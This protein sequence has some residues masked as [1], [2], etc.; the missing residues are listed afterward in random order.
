MSIRNKEY[1]ELLKH[2]FNEEKF[3]EFVIDLLNLYDSDLNRNVIENTITTKQFKDNILH[4]KHIANYNDGLNNIGVFIIKLNN[5]TTTQSRNMQRNFVATLLSKYNLDAC[6]VSFYSDRETS[7]RLSFVKRELS[8]TDKGIKENLTSAKRYSYLVGEHESVHTAQEF[9]FKLL[10][11]DNR[12]IT[13]EDIEKQFD[14]EKVT[15]KFF[16]EYKDKYL[17]LKEFFDKNEDFQTE[18]KNCDFDSVEFA[19]KLMG[20]IVFLYFLQKKGWLGVQLIP[21]ELSVDEYN[22]L[23]SNNDSVSQNLIRQYFVLNDDKYIVEKTKLRI[24]EIPEDIINLTNVFANTKYN[25]PWGTGRKDFIRNIFNQ[26]KIEHKNFFD[27]YLEYFFYKGLNEKRENQYFPLFN[28]KI[29]FLN[30]GLFEPLN[31]YRWSSAHFEIPNSIFSNDDKNG[32]L[33]FLDLY[34]FTIDEEEPLEKEI[35]VDPEMLGKIFENLLEIDDRKS[36]GAFYTPREIVYYMCQES[37]ANYLVNKLKINYNEIIEFIKFGDSIS[38]LDWETHLNNENSFIIGESVFEN[39]L[40]I[41]KALID[42]KVADPSV[43]SGAFPLGILNEIVKIRNNISTY[44]LILN[45]NGKIDIDDSFINEFGK[46]DLYEMKLQTIENSIYAV[47][48]ETSAIDI[49]KLRLWLSLIVDYPN[50]EEPKPLPNLDCK[51]LQGNSLVEE[52]KGVS[53]FSEKMLSNNLKNYRRNNSEDTSIGTIYIEQNLFDNKENMMN[54]MDSILDLQKK[55]FIT[56]D[57]KLKKEIKAKIDDIQIGL[58]QESL[59]NDYA[60][61]NEFLEISKK[62]QKPWFIWQL[63]FFDVF[64]N[65]NGFDIVIGN[66]PYVREKDNK[67]I[68][69]PIKCTKFGKKWYQGKMDYWFLFLH[70]AMNHINENGTISFITS[71]YWLNSAGG[72]KLRERIKKELSFTEIVDIGKLKVFDNVVGYHIITSYQKQKND[73]YLYKKLENHLY[74]IGSNEN[75]ENITIKELNFKDSFNGKS[76]E[77][78]FEEKEKI[79]GVVELGEICEISVGVQESP[80][81]VSKKHLDNLDDKSIQLGDGVFVVNQ[82]ELDNMHLSVDEMK[83]IHKYLYGGD[84]NKYIPKYDNKYLIYSDSECKKKIENGEY[85]NLKN[86]LDKY[87]SIITSSNGPYGIHRFRKKEYFISEKIVCPSMFEHPRFMYDNDNYFVGMSTNMIISKNDKFNMKYILG[88]LNSQ[89][90]EDWFYKYG[91]RRG[92]GVDISVGKLREFPIK[93]VDV[94][95]QNEVINIVDEL[96]FNYSDELQNKLNNIILDIYNN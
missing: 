93:I 89:F 23:L 6:L 38:Q 90:A 60:K 87:K 25:M 65:N 57:N 11:I 26:A 8:F 96:I 50:N 86:H 58:V 59:K 36:K 84:I 61:L 72:T 16:E 63:E 24:T 88:I 28:C 22:E 14:V 30:G 70:N 92:I 95:K 49:A 76:N 68:F 3:V 37:I 79:N 80:D 54:L 71:R 91:K 12:K 64:K 74:D 78:I 43:G 31:N 35:A 4:Y 77:I 75:T 39:L 46:R 19:K 13:L 27:D 69:E 67:E 62:R 1:I 73:T 56:S 7:W 83:N 52:Y 33:D 94:S 85:I 66:P 29:P 53:L 34:N 20:Q 48:I 40:N 41:D 2:S 15:K 17:E 47:D 32:I 42:V 45:E 18:A 21:N 5:T 81:S 44:L 82:I 9:L 55:Y 10:E 51:I